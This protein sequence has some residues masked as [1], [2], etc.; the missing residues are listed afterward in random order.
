[1]LKFLSHSIKNKLIVSIALLHA[2]LMTVFVFDLVQRQQIFLMEE[3]YNYTTGIAKTLAVNSIPW[4]LSNDLAGLDE[5][6]KA[7]TEQPNLKFA[8]ITDERGQIL[9]YHHEDL[10]TPKLVGKFIETEPLTVAINSNQ[11]EA[12]FNNYE[13]QLDV[14][15]PIQVQ[16]TLIGWARVD[17]NRKHIT[18]SI[19]LLSIEGALY[20]L[21]AIS[22]GGFI[23]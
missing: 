10:S 6:I 15:V 22:I 16:D 3:S 21:F 13:T 8:M 19:R 4:V 20:I 12:V 11:S 14:A 1:M 9:A 7:Q 18:D 5:I 23:A 17:I 2:V